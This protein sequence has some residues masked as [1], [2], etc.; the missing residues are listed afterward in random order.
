MICSTCGRDTDNNLDFCVYCGS[1][2][3]KPE[4]ELETTVMADPQ[5]LPH[6]A[7][8][9]PN[10]NSAPVAPAAPDFSASVAPE[11]SV[12]EFAL[13]GY[14][15]NA[16]TA[17]IFS[18][19]SMALSNGIGLVFFF[20]AKGKLNAM[21]SQ[22]FNFQSEQLNARLKS[23]DKKA[24]LAGIFT[25]IGLILN[26]IGLVGMGMYFFGMFLIMI[27]EML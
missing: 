21:K 9:V 5:S 13:K 2:L 22:N 19:I 4:G 8:S 15:S 7:P 27:G 20:L 12:Q 11:D 1:P 25:K 18:I 16:I 24:H 3:V 6:A 10:F 14:E 17:F 23:A 26:I